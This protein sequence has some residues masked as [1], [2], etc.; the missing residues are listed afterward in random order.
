MKKS[1]L[2]QLIKE[3]LLNEEFTMKYSS[4]YSTFSNNK[5]E[6]NEVIDDKL[7]KLLKYFSEYYKIDSKLNRLF[8]SSFKQLEKIKEELPKYQPHR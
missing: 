1:E 5:N 2:R 8:T 7:I 3:E 4:S 6:L